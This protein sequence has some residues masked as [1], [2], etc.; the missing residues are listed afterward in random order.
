MFA[1]WKKNYDKP[2]QHNKKQRHYFP[3]KGPYSQSYDFSNVTYGCEMRTIKKAECQT[4]DA[5]QLW[6][7]RR[8]L[9]LLDSK[10][11]KPVNPK[12]W[13]FIGR[14][15]AE[16]PI[17]WPPDVKSRLTGRPMLGK[18]AGRRKGQHRVRWLD[19][20]TDSMDMS[21]SK[22]Q[23]MVKDREAWRAAV[24][25]SYDWTAEQQQG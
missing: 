11:I 22:L 1:P 5:F 2:R 17:L 4:I 16:P 18:I 15:D 14:T 24:H 9:R 25:G 12:P 10:K 20:I 19:T 3:D 13:I 23:E 8:L 6:C 21:L 7:S